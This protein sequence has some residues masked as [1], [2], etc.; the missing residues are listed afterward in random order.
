MWRIPTMPTL[1]EA[2]A[3]AI[4]FTTIGQDN[5]RHVVVLSKGRLQASSWHAGCS[6]AVDDTDH[7]RTKDIVAVNAAD[8]RKILTTVSPSTVDCKRNTLHLTD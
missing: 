3:K 4:T 7:W 8:L 6:V 5:N 1:K 2:V